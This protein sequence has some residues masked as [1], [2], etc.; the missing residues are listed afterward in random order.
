MNDPNAATWQWRVNKD[1]RE[2]A[3]RRYQ[4]RFGVTPPQPLERKDRQGITLV[5]AIGGSDV[6]QTS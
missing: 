5:Y 4:E 3:D 6:P 2:A 1:N